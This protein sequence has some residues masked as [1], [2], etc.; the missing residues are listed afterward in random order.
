M[1]TM[2]NKLGWSMHRPPIESGLKSM[3]FHGPSPLW[4]IAAGHVWFD[5]PAHYSCLS[6]KT[7]GSLHHAAEF[8]WELYNQ[9]QGMKICLRLSEYG[10]RIKNNATTFIK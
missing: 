6:H 5:R 3:V 10:Y 7:L 1:H 4:C 9:P 2:V 8:D